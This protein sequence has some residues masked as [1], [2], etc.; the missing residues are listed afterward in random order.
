MNEM[1]NYNFYPSCAPNFLYNNLSG[2]I[3]D[4]NGIAP[5][6]FR[7][8]EKKPGIENRAV[9]R[10]SALINNHTMDAQMLRVW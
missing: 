5:Q 7:N 9:T 10:M 6:T 4:E 1:S 3:V 8:S 2:I